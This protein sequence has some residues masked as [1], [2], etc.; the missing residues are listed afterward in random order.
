MAVFY[1][2]LLLGPK[3]LK[4]VIGVAK[5]MHEAYEAMQ[6]SFVVVRDAIQCQTL[7]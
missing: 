5:L 6:Y 1:H 4:K 3:A 2:K 7:F